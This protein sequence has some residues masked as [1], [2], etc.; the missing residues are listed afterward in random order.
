MN[1]MA[2]SQWIDLAAPDGGRFKAWLALP[3]ASTGPGILLLQEIFGVNRHIRAVAEQYAMDGFVVLAPDVF[4]RQEPGLDIGYGAADLERGRALKQGLDLKQAAGDL[5]A[6]AAA[7]RSRPDCTG[8]IASLGYCMG[9]LLSFLCAAG[10]AVDAAVCYY[11]SGIDSRPEQ[12]A[13]TRC[14]LLMN[15]AALD[16]LIPVQA[17][18]RIR[19]ELKGR[20]DATVHLYPDVGH[21]FNCWDRSAYHPMSAAL[22]HGRTL[23]FLAS[24]L[25]G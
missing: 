5:A 22:A 9:G 16:D 6:A 7:L 2:S 3:P 18:D 17:V 25:S 11:G 23:Q 14:P 12:L 21:G 1:G 20:S 4:W 19:A 13:S 10:G 8:R 24:N 15:F